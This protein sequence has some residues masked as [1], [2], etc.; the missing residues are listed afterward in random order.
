MSSVPQSMEATTASA[1]ARVDRARGAHPNGWWGMLMLIATEAALF[2]TFFGS[3][4]YLRFKTVP[5]PPPGDPKPALVVPLVLTGVLVLT[6]VPMQLAVAAA[7]RAQARLAWWLV[8]AAL[9]VQSGYFAMQIH[10]YLEDLHKATP[11]RDAYESIYFTLLGAHH[12]HVFVGL[13]LDLW[14]LL[15]LVRGLTN[16]RLVG[17]RAITLYWH[18]VN[19]LALAVIGAILSAR[20]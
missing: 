9:V 11:Q 7:R 6:S 4:F 15:K 13:L 12:G 20:V 2:G 8:L 14:L 10:L 17:L 5:W 19:V 3:Y 18:F 1:A 16:Y